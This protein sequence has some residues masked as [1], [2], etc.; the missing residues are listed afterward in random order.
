MTLGDEL[1]GGSPVSPK[2]RYAATWVSG[3]VFLVLAVGAWFLPVDLVPDPAGRWGI[4]LV[5]G[6][7]VASCWWGNRWIRA[8][9]RRDP[10]A[11]GRDAGAG[12]PG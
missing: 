4:C 8:G 2:A 1:F 9:M 11:E 12:G 7:L 5:S 6:A 3:T 10:E